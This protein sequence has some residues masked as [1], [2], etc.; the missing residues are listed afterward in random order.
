[1]TFVKRCFWCLAK[2]LMASVALLNIILLIQD[3]HS[4]PGQD[5]YEIVARYMVPLILNSK[6]FY[7]VLLKY[8]GYKSSV[9]IWSVTCLISLVINTVVISYSK[10][11]I[12]YIPVSSYTATN[13][14][15]ENLELD[16][17]SKMPIGYMICLLL[18]LIEIASLLVATVC[19]ELAQ[20][21]DAPLLPVL[22]LRQ[23]QARDCPPRYTS[24]DRLI[25]L[26][27]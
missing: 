16:Y 5:A 27:S 12:F 21:F 4:D 10:R 14:V 2:L 6:S 23:L 8:R 20:E 17:Y 24:R 9:L 26:P 3:L 13:F 15:I 22:Y 18:L 7:D 25:S 11:T 1:M 19:E